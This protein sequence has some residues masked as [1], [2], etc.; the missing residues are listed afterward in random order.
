M[1]APENQHVNLLVNVKDLADYRLALTDKEVGILFG[2]GPETIYGL[3]RAGKLPG[4]KVGKFLRFRLPDVIKYW[5][6]EESDQK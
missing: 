5:E 6:N 1:N 4:K 2:V 3:Y